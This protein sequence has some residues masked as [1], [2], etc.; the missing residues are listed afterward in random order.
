MR[1]HRLE[2][3]M[4]ALGYNKEIEVAELVQEYL[5]F[6]DVGN[7]KKTTVCAIMALMKKYS[8]NK[9]QYKRQLTALHEFF[10]KHGKIISTPLHGDKYVKFAQPC[11]GRQNMKEFADDAVRICVEFESLYEK[12]IYLYISVC[13]SDMYKF[14]RTLKSMERNEIEV[15]NQQQKSILKIIEEKN[16]RQRV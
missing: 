15:K 16:E 6:K 11:C 9:I 1:E 4:K 13:Q 12:E 10:V 2:D 8:K 7:I 3:Y 5:Y 14:K